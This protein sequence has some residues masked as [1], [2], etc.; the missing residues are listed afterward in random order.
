MG[1]KQ[2]TTPPLLSPEPTPGR[3]S[4]GARVRAYF[5]T[6][7]LVAG[8]LAITAYITWWLI[9]LIDGWMRPLIPTA[10]N[11][12]TYLRFSV[13]GVGL[14]AAFVGLTLLGFLTANLVGRS[15]VAFGERLLDRTPFVRSL[16]K[17]VKQIFETVFKQDGTS[18]RR[19]GLIEWPGP[20][21]WSICL[22]SEH[23]RG[24]LAAAM[25]GDGYLN[26]F[27]PCTPNPTTGYFVVMHESL[28]KDLDVS[29]DEAFKMIMSMGIIQP[30]DRL[31]QLAALPPQAAEPSLP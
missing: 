13:P 25:P 22:V 9:A 17:G 15:F 2:P 14:L 20:G 30:E 18:F 23:T 10:Y 3:G 19:V 11:P 6:G 27:V 21:L 31:P 12:E 29:T 28:I 5:F 16:Y 4:F 24:R 8:P 26:V 1:S 7:L